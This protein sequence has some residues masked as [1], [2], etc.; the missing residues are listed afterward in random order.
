M[1]KCSMVHSCDPAVFTFVARIHQVAVEFWW[2]FGSRGA[3]ALPPASCACYSRRC[4]CYSCSRAG[5]LANG[6]LGSHP[7]GF[8]PE[9]AE[10]IERLFF[11]LDVMTMYQVV[12]SH[13]LDSAMVKSKA[14]HGC[15]E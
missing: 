6:C 10:K 1:Y 13:G 2:M 11:S 3:P 15:G 4:A 12:G 5:Q 9:L 8:S 7:A 14:V